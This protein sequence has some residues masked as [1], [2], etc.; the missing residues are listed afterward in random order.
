[1]KAD[2]RGAG[3]QDR[4]VC[5]QLIGLQRS[6]APLVAARPAS[7]SAVSAY[8]RDAIALG[9]FPERPS[10]RRSAPAQPARPGG[11]SRSRYAELR[12]SGLHRGQR[13]GHGPAEE[14]GNPDCVRP[15]GRSAGA[16]GEEPRRRRRRLPH[17]LLLSIVQAWQAAQ[18][19]PSPSPAH[20]TQLEQVQGVLRNALLGAAAAAVVAGGVG[21][22]GSPALPAAWAGI[23]GGAVTNAKASRG[24]AGLRWPAGWGG[25]GVASWAGGQWVAGQVW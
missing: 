12:H 17:L 3:V 9:P 5:G 21:P 7:H 16:T 20:I 23:G 14:P 15:T 8:P 19:T 18:P 1:M 10:P 4:N 24:G 11:T 22:E 25:Q 13:P 6:V 2:G